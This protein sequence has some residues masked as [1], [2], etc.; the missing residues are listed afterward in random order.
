MFAHVAA[1]VFISHVSGMQLICNDIHFFLFQVDLPTRGPKFLAGWPEKQ[2]INLEW[3]Y[4][5]THK[6]MLNS[7]ISFGM[8]TFIKEMVE[9]VYISI[10][11]FI[12][13]LIGT[14]IVIL[15]KFPHR[16]PK[17]GLHI[18]QATPKQFQERLL[19]VAGNLP[20]LITCTFW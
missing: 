14:Y 8:G 16:T 6:H 11:I 2:Q 7:L 4:L 5:Q 1:A 18:L 9:G 13:F 12:G 20:F 17:R 3:P 19:D 15:T 10:S